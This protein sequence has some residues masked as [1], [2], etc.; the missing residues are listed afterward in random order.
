MLGRVL[1]FDNNKGYGF[2]APA[3]QTSVLDEDIFF[4]WTA[5]VTNEAF[6]TLMHGQPVEFELRD[7]G[8]RKVAI[9]VKPMPFVNEAT[10]KPLLLVALMN[11]SEKDVTIQ[12]FQMEIG[13]KELR[14]LKYLYFDMEERYIL[15]LSLPVSTFSKKDICDVIYPSLI[16][17]INK[18]IIETGNRLEYDLFRV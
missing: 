7:E 16:T 15:A 12:K 11:V 6:K 18:K 8:D 13:S 1:W 14:G 2:I 4:H 17:Q 10:G 5:I 3:D 9:G